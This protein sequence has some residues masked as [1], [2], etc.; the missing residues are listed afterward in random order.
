M[1]DRFNPRT[2]GDDDTLSDVDID[3]PRQLRDL[4]LRIAA[5]IVIAE[6]MDSGAFLAALGFTSRSTVYD[7]GRDTFEAQTRALTV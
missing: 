1:T 2:I 4:K 7:A 6:F 3:T 5:A